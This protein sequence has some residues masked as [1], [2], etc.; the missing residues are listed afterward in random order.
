MLTTDG[1]CCSRFSS[2]CV[3]KGLLPDSDSPFL[4]T[5][6]PVVFSLVSLALKV[7]G[8]VIYVVLAKSSSVKAPSEAGEAGGSG[9]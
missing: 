4:F 1:L 5:I 7:I 3:E 9:F 2:F 6:T 8:P